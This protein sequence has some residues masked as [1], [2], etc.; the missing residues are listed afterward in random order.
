V[1][2]LKTM[3]M[4]PEKIP[5]SATK[6]ERLLQT[7][8]DSDI[9]YLYGNKILISASTVLLRD[10]DLKDYKPDAFENGY[11]ETRS[12]LSGNIDVEY[13]LS[14]NPANNS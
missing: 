10:Q 6:H 2:T 5:D 8:S 14:Y 1:Q 7:S 12:T 4:S 13:R 3:V 11:I 9:Y